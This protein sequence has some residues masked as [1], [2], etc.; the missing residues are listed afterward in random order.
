[1]EE[2][3]RIQSAN[4]YQVPRGRPPCA[5]CRWEME[6]ILLEP[7]VWVEKE[8]AQAGGVKGQS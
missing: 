5:V 6:K 1:M 3:T 2:K 8:D 7:V 4:P